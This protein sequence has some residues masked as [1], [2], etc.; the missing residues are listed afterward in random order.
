[1]VDGIEYT[2]DLSSHEFIITID[3]ETDLIG[4]AVFGDG[5]VYVRNCCHL[6]LV[7]EQH[8]FILVLFI[9]A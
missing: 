7:G 4:F 5:H 9:F 6:L 3:E 1:L 8:Y 2:E